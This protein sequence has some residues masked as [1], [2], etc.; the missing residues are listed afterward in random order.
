MLMKSYKI[1]KY[2]QVPIIRQF[3]QD[4]TIKILYLSLDFCG[5]PYYGF[6]EMYIR[7][8]MLKLLLTLAQVLHNTTKKFSST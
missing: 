4:Q 8:S 5:S 3:S 6:M 2:S 1:S 7:P